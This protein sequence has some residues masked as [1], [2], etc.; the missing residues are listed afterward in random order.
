MARDYSI[1]CGPNRKPTW[2]NNWE[3]TWNY[4]HPSLHIEFDGKIPLE[5]RG[6]NRSRFKIDREGCIPRQSDLQRFHP[7]Q[8]YWRPN[9]EQLGPESRAVEETAEFQSFVQ[10]LRKR[11]QHFSQHD[12]STLWWIRQPGNQHLR[13]SNHNVGKRKYDPKQPSND[14]NWRKWKKSGRWRWKMPERLYGIIIL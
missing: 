1:R 4:N 8:R 11:C 9:I 2:Q 12:P 10:H 6:A 14:Q 5:C 3:N 13:F 7:E